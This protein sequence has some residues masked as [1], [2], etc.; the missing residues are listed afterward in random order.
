MKPLINLNQAGRLC[1]RYRPGRARRL[2]VALCVFCGC[3]AVHAAGMNSVLPLASGCVSITNTQKNS[4]WVPVAVL[5]SFDA[6]VSG[7]LAI[8]RQTDGV[9]FLLGTVTL[10]VNQYAMWILDAPISFNL[11]DV[12]SV[13]SSMTNGTVEII[14]KAN[15]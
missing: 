4:S 9:T 8:T 6:P 13:T 11:N 1:G 7:S 2:A 3:C 10:S 15:P 5:F 14:R 12:L